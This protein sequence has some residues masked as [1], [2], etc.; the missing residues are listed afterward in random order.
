MKRR[1]YLGLS[2]FMSLSVVLGAFAR[3]DFP[4]RPITVIVN[5]SAG[6]G[7]DMA[8][9]AIAK[10]AEKILG[11]PI[12]VVNKAGAGGTVGAGAVAAAKPD[13]Y[14]IGVITFGP[15]TMAPH[16]FD[17]PY[18]PLKDFEY[19]LGYARLIYGIEVRTDSQFKTLKDLVQYAKANPGKIKYGVTGLSIPTHFAMVKLAKAEGIKWDPVVFKS[20]T[21]GV[22]AILGGNIEVSVQDPPDVVRYINAGRLRLLA[23]FSDIRWPW[24]ADVP[25]AR[26]LGYNVAVESWTSMAAPKGVPRPIM[27]KLVDAFKQSNEDPEFIKTL[28]EGVRMTPAYRTGEQFQELVNSGYKENE[29]MILE[30]GLHKS[31][32]KQ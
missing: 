19:I 7:Q 1:V 23:S 18:N 21:E 3:A 17:L 6:G 30:L 25:T 2:L 10:K 11:Q 4:E 20:T 24:V 27:D 31:Q 5:Y 16:M 14:T 22:A 9:R 26:E 28:I 8:A 29:A 13:G 32:K 12:A 15:V